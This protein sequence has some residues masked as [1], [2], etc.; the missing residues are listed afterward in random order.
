M[1]LNIGTLYAAATYCIKRFYYYQFMKRLL[2][3]LVAILMG[4]AFPLILAAQGN[5]RLLTLTIKSN[6]L[7]S[8]L[9][10]VDAAT[11]FKIF[12]NVDEAYPLRGDFAF[13]ST[14]INDILGQL[15]ANTDY[16]YIE[17]R[18]YTWVVVD[19]SIVEQ[20]YSAEFYNALGGQEEDDI[21]RIIIGDISQLSADGMATISGIVTDAQNDEPILGATI[22]VD[23]SDLGT[24]SDIDGSY[25][26]MVSA[27]PHEVTINFIGY[28]ETLLNIDVKSN[29][30]FD[31][32]L[33]KSAIEL[34][35]V[36]I[37]ART[38]D[39]NLQSVQIGVQSIDISTI[40]KLP[41]F[42]GEVDVIKSFLLQPGVS[43]IGE[44]SSGFNVRGGNVDQ[45][46]IMQDE[47]FLFNSS[48]SLGFFSTFNSDLISRVN[49]YKANIPAQY[50]GRL[51][52]VMDVEMR[53]GNFERF[54]IKG[55]IGPI[56]SKVSFEGPIIKDKVSMI[57][58]FRSSYTDWLLTS[59]S[60]PE[61]QKSSSFFYDANFRITAKPSANHS[62]TLSAYASQDDFVYND[63]FGFDYNTR[64]AEFSYGAIIG[65]NI[66]SKFTVVGSTYNS[67]QDD[68]DPATAS[69][70]ETNVDYL[71]IKENIKYIPNEQT[72]FNVGLSAINYYINPGERTPIGDLSIVP[73][74]K[75]EQ[76]KGR[77]SAAYA[78]AKLEL[79]ESLDISAGARLTY[80]QYLGPKTEYQ[81]TDEFRPTVE[82]IIG[83]ELKSGTIESYSYIEP[84]VSARLKLAPEASIKAGYSRT[85]QFINQIFN[86]D[87]PT[88]TSQWQ[89]S[90][91]Y[92]APLRSHNL[93]LGYFKNFSD[94]VWETSIEFY[95]RQIDQ[96]FDYQD[97]PDLLI[98]D[99]LETELLDGEGRTYGAELSI[100]K[101][102]GVMNGWLSYTYS[103]SE[104][105]IDGIN[106]GE[107]YPSNFDKTHDVSLILNYNPNQR[108]TLT[109][110]INYST[111]RPI[112]APVGN[113][114]TSGGVL[115]PVFSDRNALRIPDYFRVDLAYTL[116]K[117]YKV[118]QKFRTS[119]TISVYNVLGRKNPYSVFFE[120]AAF[121]YF[122]ANK[123]SII[124]S[125]F[126][127]LTINFEL[128]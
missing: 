80:Y 33:P 111:G 74:G 27:G 14:D 9:E 66:T 1:N 4:V 108:N 59:L 11:P 71:K 113:Y 117:S 106:R 47:T 83:T 102:S 26:I 67:D 128:L 118:D 84:R 51:V 95:G 22:K 70:I 96:L 88:P 115:I 62:F 68:F 90:N 52:S 87:S 55:G 25:E 21:K 122:Q 75:L 3:T 61:L 79:T 121:D 81:Y 15:L 100:K 38:A 2:L 17:Y 114:R 97:F 89:L 54:K 5:A 45:N 56:S 72:E 73:Y 44:G 104:R 7:K 107:W 86:A 29:G 58:G 64:F 42:L 39:Q 37:S 93:S 92:I 43:S 46:L 50:G 99:H 41:T 112:T 12:T 105:K 18:G 24:V 109:A 63:E 20:D 119:W 6:T 48:H 53:D 78:N 77:E 91:R 28:Q 35:E 8:A 110:N 34:D 40:E 16:E 120:K 19:R 49:L 94:N 98:N 57:G 32:A 31:I 23:D 30:Q 116:G 127:S 60:E 103:K 13:E 125:A 85:S 82:G 76:E 123:F 10:E 124:G 65:S 126:P 69:T 36:T 101:G